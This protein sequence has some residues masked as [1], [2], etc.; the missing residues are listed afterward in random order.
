VTV[1]EQADMTT[2]PRIA[3]T[4]GSGFI[5]RWTVR[6]LVE[7]G[8]RVAVLSHNPAQA[9]KRLGD[10]GTRVTVRYADAL[11]RH[12]FPDALIGIEVVIN[13]MQFPGFPVEQPHRNWTFDA[14]D[15]Q[16]T[17]WLLDAAQAMGVRRFVYLS[18]ITVNADAPL[19]PEAWNRAKWHAE[20]AVRAS[21]L[22]W[23]I[24]RPAW[25]YGPDDKTL[26][27]IAAQARYS[28]VMVV[29]GRKLQ[30]VQPVHVADLAAVVA[31][32]VERA[33]TVGQTY[34][35]AG[36]EPVE[37]AD[38]YRAVQRALAVSRPIVRVPQ[39]IPKMVAAL[40]ARL[41][42]HLLTPAAINFV[43]ASAIAD[44]QPA[45][46]TFGTIFRSLDDGLRYLHTH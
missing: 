44:A 25:V 30:M 28:P 12:S 5:G 33:E 18:G 2:R 23:T 8:E 1:T 29:I 40:A 31:D 37:I 43:T 45:I 46:E 19:P 41:P 35:I 38:L 34:V 13:A 3:I 4:G 27:L 26:N 9:R 32:C 7:R 24:L 6:A 15:R 21:S 42:R 20:H 39:A 17:A 22:D 11:D 36:V 14:V 10:L 16:G